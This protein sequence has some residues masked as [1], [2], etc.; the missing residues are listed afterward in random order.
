V[1]D[2]IG[3]VL[4][5][6]IPLGIDRVSAAGSHCAH[7]AA[8]RRDQCLWASASDITCP[9]GR[10]NLGL[11]PQDDPVVET[12]IA[13]LLEWGYAADPTAA[14]YFISG[15]VPIPYGDPI[16]VYGPP[17][18]LP[19][20]PDITLRIVTPEAAMRWIIESAGS[21]GVR[22]VGDMSG[23]GAVCGECT[24]F[25]LQSGRVCVSVG[26]PGSR[27]ELALDPTELLLAIP[28]A[29]EHVL[30]LDVL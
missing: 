7:V 28:R 24:A 5:D 19:H 3:I 20:E 6:H 26:C 12:L 18:R 14:R 27:R 11:D 22:A 13:T 10:F 2:A 1:D 4:L 25:P 17:D 21:S 9:L 30:P 29:Q 15:L 16:L 23:L 8:G